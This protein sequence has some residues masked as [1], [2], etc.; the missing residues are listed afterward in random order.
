MKRVWNRI[1]CAGYH[2]ATTRY[3]GSV[4]KLVRHDKDSCQATLSLRNDA[5]QCD[6]PTGHQHQRTE[7]AAW[8]FLRTR[9]KIADW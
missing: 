5:Q 3:K 8:N 1:V 4:R 7:Q 6:G 2:N 9:E